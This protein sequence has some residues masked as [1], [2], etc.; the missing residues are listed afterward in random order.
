MEGSDIPGSVKG[1][2]SLWVRRHN[3]DPKEMLKKYNQPFLG[4][5]GQ[6]DWVVPYRE[7]IERLE[8]CFSG[9]RRSLLSTAIAYGGAHGTETE[10]QYVQLKENHSYWHFF[11]ISATPMIEIVQFLRRHNFID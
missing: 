2:D 3:Y 8:D 7:N 11:R 9:E 6:K 1:I 10:S 5:Y 4:I